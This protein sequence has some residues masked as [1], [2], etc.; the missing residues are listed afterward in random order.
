M[1]EKAQL[2]TFPS[3]PLKIEVSSRKSQLSDPEVD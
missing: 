3:L 2:V 1:K